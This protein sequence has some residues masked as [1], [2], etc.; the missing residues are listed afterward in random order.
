[1]VCSFVDSKRGIMDLL[2]HQS[3]VN[4]PGDVTMAFI[5][6]ISLQLKQWSI[7]VHNQV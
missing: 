6:N 7:D 5:I 1:M 3:S 2:L 4:L